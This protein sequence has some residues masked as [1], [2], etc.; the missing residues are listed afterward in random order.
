MPALPASAGH[1][2][3]GVIAHTGTGWRAPASPRI[4]MGDVGMSARRPRTTKCPPDFA[5]TQLT[6]VPVTHRVGS[7]GGNVLIAR[8]T[9]HDKEGFQRRPPTSVK[10]LGPAAQ[11]DRTYSPD[12]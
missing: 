12:V 9:S 4:S 1:R 3:R 6:S 2:Q 7:Q 8:A 10:E 5:R 11:E